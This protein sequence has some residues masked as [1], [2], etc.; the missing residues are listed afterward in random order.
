MGLGIGTLWLLDND[1]HNATSH[2]R[3]I[4][5]GWWVHDMFY[6]RRTWHRIILLLHDWTRTFVVLL[7]LLKL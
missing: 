2:L 5:Y 7:Y 6:H 4:V 1:Q 3:L